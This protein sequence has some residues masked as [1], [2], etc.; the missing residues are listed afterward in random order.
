MNVNRF[1]VALILTAAALTGI[2]CQS[3]DEQ[4]LDAARVGNVVK[5]EQ[6]EAKGADVNARSTGGATPMF[7]A[8]GN[9]HLHAMKWLNDRGANV[10]A[11][12]NDDWAPMHA[13]AFF[14]RLD[15]MRWLHEQG[16]DI[17]AGDKRGL[18]PMHLT[19]NNGYLDVMRWLHKQGADIEPRD[20]DGQ[21]PMHLAA[22]RDSL[23]LELWFVKQWKHRHPMDENSTNNLNVLE[24]LK[25]QGA[26]VNAKDKNGRTPLASVV[27]AK[28]AETQ[29]AVRQAFSNNSNMMSLLM[30]PAKTSLLDAARDWLV[31]NGGTM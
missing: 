25:R 3:L 10:H 31:Q 19:A 2:G 4:F 12:D 13:A 11:K 22:V 1:G 24:W 6:L 26:D 9:G 7:V 29:I 23:M 20:R 14:G 17:H 15:V 28:E 30:L 16:A 18:T 21:T 5:M 27:A 8:A